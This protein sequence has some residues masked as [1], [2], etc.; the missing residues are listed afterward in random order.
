MPIKQNKI[1]GHRKNG[2]RLVDEAPCII[3]KIII[4]II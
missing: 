1:I 2:L 4:I 3:I